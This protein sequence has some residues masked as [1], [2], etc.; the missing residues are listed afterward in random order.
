MGCEWRRSREVIQRDAVASGGSGIAHTG[1]AR[2]RREGRACTID[3]EIVESD[4]SC[5]SGGHRWVGEGGAVEGSRREGQMTG[6]GLRE[7]G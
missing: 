4:E 5:A 3:G 1:R 2:E 7:G 6:T